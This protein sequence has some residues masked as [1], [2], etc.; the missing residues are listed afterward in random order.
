M[1]SLPTRVTSPMSLNIPNVPSE[2]R[3]PPKVLSDQRVRIK[4]T[5]DS[6]FET[7]AYQ[8]IRFKKTKSTLVSRNKKMLMS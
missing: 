8:G 1:F 6:L 5:D 3:N 7:Q 2:A 4:N